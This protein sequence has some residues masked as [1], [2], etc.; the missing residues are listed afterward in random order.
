MT[1]E[2]DDGSGGERRRLADA[3]WLWDRVERC[4]A[5]TG[6]SAGLPPAA[7]ANRD[8]M[9]A[10]LLS[11]DGNAVER[12]ERDRHLLLVGGA[13]TFQEWVEAGVFQEIWRRGLIEYDTIVGIDWG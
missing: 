2:V 7:G 13:S 10:I 9:D 8:A 4:C 3:D 1:R 6:A 12:V 11:V 5:G